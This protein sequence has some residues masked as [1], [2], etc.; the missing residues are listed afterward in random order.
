MPIV[1]SQPRTIEIRANPGERLLDVVDGENK[2]DILFECRGAT[3]GTCLVSIVD[4]AHLIEPPSTLE[5]QTLL[6]LARQSAHDRLACQIRFNANQ[7]T[8][9]LRVLPPWHESA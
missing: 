7:G 8:L 6:S 2:S 4:G 1:A 9:Q 5:T 3:C